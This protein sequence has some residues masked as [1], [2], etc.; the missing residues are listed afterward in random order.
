MM[1]VILVSASPRRRALLELL[2]WRV[3][4]R[5]AEVEESPVEGLS[6]SQQAMTLAMRKLA[7]ALPALRP[8]EVALAADTIVFHGGEILGKPRN[9]E[10]ARTFLRRLSGDWHTVYTGVAIGTVERA[11]AFSEATAVRFHPLPDALIETY[12]RVSP[13]LDKAGAYGAQDLIGLAGI[14]EIRGDFYNVMGLP[15]QRIT[16]FWMQ[17][18]GKLFAHAE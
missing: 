10:E 12:L 11:W 7:T 15:V 3:E 1:K 13:P 6:P 17:T 4:L 18:F 9:V 16:R 5:P 8:G 14:A 2:G